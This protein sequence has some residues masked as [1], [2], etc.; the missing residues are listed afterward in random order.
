M[1]ESASLLTWLFILLLAVWV[2]K[3]GVNH[4]VGKGARLGQTRPADG[5]SYWLLITA[6]A[7]SLMLA[8]GSRAIEAALLPLWLR[9][10]G[11]GLMVAGLILRQWAVFTLG[12]HFSVVVAIE[13]DHQL[14]Q[15][16]PYRWLRHPA[17]TGGLLAALGMQLVMGN[18]WT[19]LLSMLLLL[20]AFAYRIRIEERALLAHFGETYR[21]YQQSTWRLLPGW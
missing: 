16:G 2:V 20:L 6:A 8:L 11:L 5:G 12:R 3:E 14:I 19:L 15:S 13:D 9:Y 1:L 21:A 4:L 18:G 17:Y 7:L 10:S